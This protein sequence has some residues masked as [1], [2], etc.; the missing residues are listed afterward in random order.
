M[1][2]EDEKSRPYTLNEKLVLALC[3][4]CVLMAI[5]AIPFLIKM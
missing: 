2:H 5:A 4:V 3:A 1:K